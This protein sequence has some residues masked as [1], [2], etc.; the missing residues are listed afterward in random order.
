MRAGAVC[1]AI[2][3]L[4]D[5]AFLLIGQGRIQVDLGGWIVAASL[6]VAGA[7]IPAYTRVRE[8]KGITAIGAV[9]GLVYVLGVAL[10]SGSGL[11]DPV[12]TVFATPLL[13]AVFAAL[14]WVG[15]LGRL[16]LV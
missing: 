14:V 10:Q 2:V 7:L 16:V 4:V 8:W 13:M 5:T 11:G 9:A 3:G 15:N 1:G 12:M 6:I